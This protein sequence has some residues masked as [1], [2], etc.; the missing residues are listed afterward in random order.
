MHLL[1]KTLIFKNENY[2]FLFTLMVTP[3]PVT[4]KL[5][6]GQNII[7]FRLYWVYNTKNDL[8]IEDYT[9]Y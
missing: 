3:H 1:H 4:I 9:N 8:M 7:G 5:K 2:L 6:I